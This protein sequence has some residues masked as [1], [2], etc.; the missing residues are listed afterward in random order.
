MEFIMRQSLFKKYSAFMLV[1]L[2]FFVG[3]QSMPKLT[4]PD[5]VYEFDTR[6]TNDSDVPND[7]LKR[8]AF[9]TQRRGYRYFTLTNTAAG[10]DA[11]NRPTIGFN[12]G[13]NP[14]G[15][16]DAGNQTNG[17]ISMDI[18]TQSHRIHWVV[19]MFHTT[20]GDTA[21]VYDVS[22]VIRK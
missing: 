20:Q 9:T 2:L 1:P 18:P 16:S 10:S 15:F 8:A 7:V 5:N 11:S 13:R 6:L 14:Y 17:G 19:T 12:Y 22:E 21:K 3:C 4:Q